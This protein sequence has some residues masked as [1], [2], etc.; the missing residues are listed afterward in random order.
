MTDA[1]RIEKLILT[2]MRLERCMDHL[3][4]GGG[5]TEEVAEGIRDIKST[6]KHVINANEEILPSPSKE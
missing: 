5:I 2:L 4:K 1:E 6:I 3:L